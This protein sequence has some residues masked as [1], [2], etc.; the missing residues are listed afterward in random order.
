MRRREEAQISDNQLIPVLELDELDKGRKIYKTNDQKEVHWQLNGFKVKGIDNDK[1]VLICE[2]S[3]GKAMVIPFHEL[4]Q[5]YVMK[6]GWRPL[7]KIQVMFH[8]TGKKEELNRAQKYKMMDYARNLP[9]ASEKLYEGKKKN[10]WVSAPN[11]FYRWMETTQN[12]PYS[13]F[14]KLMPFSNQELW[15]DMDDDNPKILF[16]KKWYTL[17]AWCKKNSI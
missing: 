4:N 3:L 2:D 15:F 13:I 10:Y 1:E 11:K 5:Y 16:R 9:E 17:E 12:S 8:V 14:E 7:D 6:H